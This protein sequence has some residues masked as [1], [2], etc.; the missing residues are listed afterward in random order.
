MTKTIK[1]IALAFSIAFLINSCS[2]KAISTITGME[3][4]SQKNE[5]DYFVLPYG[6]V[7]IPGKWDK[8][9][10][11]EIAKQQYFK[12]KDSVIISIAFAPINKYEFNTDGKLQGFNFVHSFYEWE[13]K[14][15]IQQHK[16]NSKIIEKDSTK[17]KILFR[18]HG[19]IEQGNFDTFFMVT[20]KGNMASVFSVTRSD[21]WSRNETIDFLNSIGSQK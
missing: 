13:S 2:P 8:T 9:H 20:E 4:N 17:N 7:S 1:Y 21:K 16:L 3:Y 11:N 18:I 5:T 6:S 10:Y 19:D 15:F 14:Y 12:N